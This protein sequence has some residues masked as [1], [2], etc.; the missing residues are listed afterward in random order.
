MSINRLMFIAVSV[1]RAP[2][3][4]RPLDHLP[5]TRHFSVGQVANARVGAHARFGQELG[6]RR[7]ANA[8]DVSQSDFDALL[9]RKIDASDTCHIS[10]AAACAWDCACR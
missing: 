10:L 6:A 1:R 8:K 3:P 7:A 4:D 2:Q 9:A 5:E